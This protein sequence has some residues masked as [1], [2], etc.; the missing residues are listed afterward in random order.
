MRIL[1]Y[2]GKGG[3]GV[4]TVAAATA[5]TCAERGARTL[6][7]SADAGPALATILG[8]PVGG[9]PLPVADGLWAQRADVA[10]E[11]RT[12]WQGL[13]AW[14]QEVLAWRAVAAAP[15]AELSLLPGVDSVLTLD[16]LARH[17]EEARYDV[18]VVDGAP[19]DIMLTLLN[20]VELAGTMP[21][22]APERARSTLD[23]VGR[24]ARPYLA[25]LT[26]APLPDDALLDRLRAALAR[27]LN[28]RATLL[29]G[30]PLTVRLVLTAEQAVRAD[31]HRR[32]TALHL[33]GFQ[34]GRAHV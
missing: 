19:S 12:S 7:L 21:D 32:F 18:L 9:A 2:T 3:V 10:Y 20:L 30:G 1:L 24:L 5:L 6:L 14:L 13:G 11:E 34:I 26:A 23:L 33:H 8:R 25:R 15:V 28:L 4:T 22:I 16:L 17:A 29:D 31:T 27:L